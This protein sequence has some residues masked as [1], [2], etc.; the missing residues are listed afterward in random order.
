V[1]SFWVDTKQVPFTD[2]AFRHALYYALPKQKVIDVALGGAG[3]PARRSPI[4]PVFESWIPKDLPAEE[5]D[6]AKARKI[7][8]DNGYKWSGEKLIMK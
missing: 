3:Q 6:L 4:P 2:K 8:A 7:L 5:Y 1:V